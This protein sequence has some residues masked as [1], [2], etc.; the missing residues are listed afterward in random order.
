MTKGNHPILELES[1][2]KKVKNY[3]GCSDDYFIK[4]ML[5]MDWAL[6]TQ[7]DFTFLT[8]VDRNGKK[9]DAVVVKRGG[10]PMVF[11]AKDYTMVVAIDCVKIG[12]VFR[13][14]KEMGKTN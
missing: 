4:L 6:R 8:Y 11:R 3:F 1:V 9:S 5:E 7:E 13:N 2:Q 12:F 10:E 14:G